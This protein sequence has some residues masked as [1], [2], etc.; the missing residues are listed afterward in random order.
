MSTDSADP[1][2]WLRAIMASNRGTL[3]DLGISPIV[4][5]GLIMQFLQGIKFIEV[6][7]TPKDRALFNG[8][9]KCMRIINCFSP[10]IWYLCCLSALATAHL[11]SSVRHGDHTGAGDRV[12]D[13]GHV[14]R[15]GANGP[16]RVL[17]DRA[18]A[19]RGRH[20]RALARRAPPEGLRP[21][22]RHLAL[23]RHQHL[24]D[25]RLEEL[26]ACHYQHRPRY[27]PNKQQPVSNSDFPL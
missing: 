20:H 18:P 4:T 2:Y 19:L 25:Y 23:H 26:L 12:R 21:R 9:Q 7:D 16:F 22:Q 24:R 5:S 10:I 6:G 13:D 3:M 27:E 1:F 17:R 15:P 8:A 11:L 14:R